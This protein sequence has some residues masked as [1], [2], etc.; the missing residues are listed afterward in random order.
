MKWSEIEVQQTLNM[1][2]K[3]INYWNGEGQQWNLA[4]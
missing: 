4:D 3:K 1:G 2:A